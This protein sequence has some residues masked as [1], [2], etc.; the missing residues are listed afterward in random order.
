MDSN[1]DIIISSK[2]KDIGDNFIVRRSLPQANKRMVGP[3]IFWD[4]MGPVILENG[5]EMKVRSHPHIGLAT[6]TYL[7]SGEILHRDSLQNEQYIKP[8]EVNWMT[9]GSGI[10]HSERAFSKEEKVVLEGIQL[11]VAL[12]REHEDIAP[13]FVHMKEK[14]LPMIEQDGFKLR[15]IAGEAFKQKSPIPVYSDL[16]YLSGHANK[17]CPFEYK[18][19]ENAEGAVYIVDG[20]VRIDGNTY[21]RFNLIT[22][23]KGSRISFDVI[24]DVQFMLF[25]GEV[26]PEKRHIWWNFVSSDK[27]RIEQAKQDWTEGKFDSVINETEMIPLPES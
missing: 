15:L 18:L 21:E 1:V 25:G 23:K 22:F 6:I 27:A 10:V 12:P 11:W 16:F 14:E 9:A 2:V 7:F 8:G 26:F 3:F 19:K 5:K 13:S 4:H 20:K 24:E 17:D